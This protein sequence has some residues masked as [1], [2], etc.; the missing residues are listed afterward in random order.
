MTNR[1][2]SYKT[3]SR[4]FVYLRRSQDR[5]DRQLLSIGKQDTQVKKIVRDHDLIPIHLP[6]E[7]RSA[8]TTGRPIFNNMMDRIETGEA[9]YITTWA[10]SRLS[11]NSVDAGRI[12]YA[13]DRGKLLAIHTPNKT[14][15]NTPDDKMILSIELAFAKKNND[16]LSVQVKE[17]FEQKRKHGQYPGPAPLGYINSIIRAGERNIQPDPSTSSK[18]IRLF[19]LAASGRYTLDHLWKE[20][21]D[22]RLLSRRGQPLSKQTMAEILKR[23]TYAGV[24]KYGGDVWHQGTYEP[25]VSLDLFNLVQLRMGWVKGT[26]EL[27]PLSTSGRSYLYKGLLLCKTCSFNVT[28]YTKPKKL[29]TGQTKEYEYYTCTRKNRKIICKESQINASLLKK[30]V[31]LKMSEFEI[32]EDD[33]K[34]CKNFVSKLHKDHLATKNQYR[35]VWLKDRADAQKALDTLDDKLENG[36]MTDDRYIKRSNKHKATIARTTELLN[37][38]DQDATRW[39]ELSNE[40]FSTATNIGDV[41]EIANDEEKRQLMIYVGS[42]WY[43]DNKK[44]ALTPREPLNLLHKSNRNTNWRARPDLN[45]RSPP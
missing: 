21:R 6:P 44:V 30:E 5:E 37:S 3:K 19:E 16:D 10:L 22:I 12:I 24:F 15:R 27:R 4:C 9:R 18:V 2:S 8:K 40:V 39:L 13:L 11:R 7:E 34:V 1:K 28:A 23:K 14:Y 43:L 41:F 35:P 38:T 17:G 36:V 33:A 45:R 32:S 29:A 20:A 42:N 31:K 26:S 25:L